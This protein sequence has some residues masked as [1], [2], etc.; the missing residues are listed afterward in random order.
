MEFFEIDMQ[1]DFLAANIGGGYVCTKG[2]QFKEESCHDYCVN[3]K[4]NTA[5]AVN[6]PTM[7]VKPVNGPNTIR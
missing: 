1:N 6:K 5:C 7:P 3:I 4:L 2:K